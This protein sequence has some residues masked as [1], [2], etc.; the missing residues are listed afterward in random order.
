MSDG[1]VGAGD[2][3]QGH[4]PDREANVPRPHGLMPRASVCF[5]LRVGPL[6][7]IDPCV[8]LGLEVTAPFMTPGFFSKT[9]L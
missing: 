3:L 5:R 8:L 7:K 6:Y 1:G 9:C 2:T 4:S